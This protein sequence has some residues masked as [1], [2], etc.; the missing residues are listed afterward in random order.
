MKPKKLIIC[1]RA[2]AGKDSVANII[3][4]HRKVRIFGQAAP[5]K[6]FAE[7]LFGFTREQ[8]Y[9]PSEKRNAVDPRSL[10]DTWSIA[11]RR[12]PGIGPM[13]LAEVIPGMMSHP[14]H[15]AYRKLIYWFED[16]RR[17]SMRHSALVPRRVLQT[18]GTD[19]GREQLGQDVWINYAARRADSYEGS[20][21]E[22][23]V[24][25]DGRFP[26]EANAIVEKGGAAWLVESSLTAA[27]D[28]ASERMLDTIPR[29]VFNHC[30]TNPKDG[31]FKRLEKQVLEG[32]SN[33]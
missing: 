18:L 26:N 3:S 5:L 20:N 10:V 25:P 14:A 32:L 1:G 17:H 21:Y 16:E 24:I 23:V 31:D 27:A 33:L 7:M 19:Y 9:G 28:H 12:L 30:I 11:Q 6:E 8:L 2:G 13:W 22:M 29:A 4:Q 15:E